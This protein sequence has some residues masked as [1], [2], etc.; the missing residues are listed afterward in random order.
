MQAV[1]ASRLKI[2]KDGS[3]V[4]LRDELYSGQDYQKDIIAN[5]L[6]THTIFSLDCIHALEGF[7]KYRSTLKLDPVNGFIPSSNHPKMI[8][9]FL[10]HLISVFEK[11]SNSDFKFI[12]W[13]RKNEYDTLYY[14][15]P[16][17]KEKILSKCSDF[18]KSLFYSKYKFDNLCDGIYIES[19][20]ELVELNLFDVLCLYSLIQK[21]Q[22][23]TKLKIKKLGFYQ[24]IFNPRHVKENEKFIRNLL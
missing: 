23:I 19:E 14:Q 8:K 2:K 17:H 21:G 9:S 18:I 24:K 16:N 3:E 12:K 7:N 13:V 10:D 6:S 11:A 5:Y 4:L 15:L 20:S 1:I 22:P